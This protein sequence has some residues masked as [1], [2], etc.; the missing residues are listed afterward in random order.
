M[1]VTYIIRVINM[2]KKLV[3]KIIH[4]L[5]K[6]YHRIFPPEIIPVIH[7][8]YDVRELFFQENCIT[9]FNRYDMIV[10]LLAI[11]N[12]Y[13][14]NNF[15]FTLYKKQ[16][17]TRK[18]EDWRNAETRFRELIESYDKNGYDNN[19]E[20]TLNKDLYL[21]D[22]SHRIALAMYHRNYQISCQVIPDTVRSSY[23]INWYVEN[24]FT[25]NEIQQIQERYY[26][27]KAEIQVPYICT[28]WAPVA[29]YF[30]EITEKLNLLCPVISYQ[31]YSYDEFAYAQIVR[32]VYAVDDIERWKIE[33]KLEYMRQNRSDGY[34]KVR[35]VKLRLDHPE[36]RRKESNNNLLSH[37]C[38]EIKRIIRNCYKDKLP[39]YFYDIICHIG[40]NFY[41]NEFIAK[42]FDMPTTI[43]GEV[44]KQL[45]KTDYSVVKF[46]TPSIPA[47]FPNS[48]PIGKDVDIVCTK[49]NFEEVL[50][51]IEGVLKKML[52]DDYLI[53]RA[54]ASDNRTQIR[55]ELE[56]RL[57]Y[58][59]DVY[60][61]I[62][63]IDISFFEELIRQRQV[64]NGIYIA[65][66]SYELV[67]RIYEIMNYPQKAHHLYYVCQ[68]I[69]SIDK[70][71]CDKYLSIEAKVVLNKIQTGELNTQNH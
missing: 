16:Q 59:F 30:D 25:L 9:G 11:E 8:T 3:C 22:G 13:G 4:I 34:W 44:F 6:I 10:R 42:I 15:G 71:L 68:N 56:N 17:E 31:D 37:R 53:R 51:I 49:E 1:G 40:D 69:Q 64:H 27:L 24:S 46:N 62:D 38:E 33:K 50:S 57:M 61:Q 39:H 2:C 21:W 20:I 67:L 23:G 65:T 52:S 60:Y 45:S 70:K 32:S 48:Y 26:R 36:Y 63:D 41:Q 12:Y 35:A 29:D 58:A 18:R 66:K 43:V 14:K 7:H 47:D 55:I 54:Y 5:K 28:L 19:S